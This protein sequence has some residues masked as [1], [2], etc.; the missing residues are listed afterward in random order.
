MDAAMK[1][2]DL[3]LNLFLATAAVPI[4]KDHP[5]YTGQ[6]VPSRAVRRSS[7]V[8]ATIV[9]LSLVAAISSGIAHYMLE[10]AARASEDATASITIAATIPAAQPTALAAEPATASQVLQPTATPTVQPSSALPVEAAPSVAAIPSAVAA[11][12]VGAK[13]FSRPWTKPIKS[14]FLARRAAAR[15]E[16]ERQEVAAFPA[17]PPAA[18]AMLFPDSPRVD[19]AIATPGIDN[20]NRR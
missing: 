11:S 14:A 2:I 13:H 6:L 4:P 19:L 5:A 12:T 16:A 10:I 7:I 15:R 20:T 1:S 9:G 8:V 3:P 18:D 17:P